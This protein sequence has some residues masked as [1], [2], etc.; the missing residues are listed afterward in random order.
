MDRPVEVIPDLDPELVTRVVARLRELEPTAI[1][2]VV[3][4]SYATGAADE[5][6]DLDIRAITQGEPGVHYRTWFEERRGVKPLHVSAGA[7]SVEAWLGVREPEEWTFGFPALGVARY[8]WSTGKSRNLIGEDPSVRF[9]PAPLEL[10]DFVEFLAKLRR[11]AA[12]DDAVGMRYYA[13]KAATL[14]PRLL[15]PLNE[16]RLVRDTSE[17]LAAVL[18]LAVAPENY[19][20]DILIALGLVAAADDAVRWAALR[21]GR[22]LLAFLR[23]RKP[24]ADPQPDIARYLADGTLERH[25]G[26]LD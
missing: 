9:A 16:E 12:H 24:D 1:A 15:R 23:E 22:E 18:S 4:G 14:A 19:R 3:T 17:A 10:E 5:H 26:F 21:L 20:D 7:K 2:V 6:S 13:R 25:L 8:V 11:S